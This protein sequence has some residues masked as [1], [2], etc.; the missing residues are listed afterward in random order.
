M[1]VSHAQ[2]R[3]FQLVLKI[4]LYSLAIIIS[5]FREMDRSANILRIFFNGLSK[6]DVDIMYDRASL[7]NQDTCVTRYQYFFTKCS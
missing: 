4:F 5:N 2:H 6:G 7:G 3:K 1:S